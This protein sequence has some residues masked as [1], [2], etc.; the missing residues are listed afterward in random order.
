MNQSLKIQSMKT[1]LISIRSLVAFSFQLAA[2]IEGTYRKSGGALMGVCLIGFTLQVCGESGPSWT[3]RALREQA[4]SLSVV[5]LPAK[6]AEIVSDSPEK[7]RKRLAV[8]IVR[9]FLKERHSL[10]PSLVGSICSAAPDVSVVVTAEAVQLFPESAYSIVK[11][12]VASAPEMAVSIC[13]Q[14]SIEV[15]DR[16]RQ[17]VNAVRRAHPSAVTELIGVVTVLSAARVETV[18]AAI[19]STRNRIGTSLSNVPANLN[20]FRDNNSP[21]L[22]QL[23]F[24]DGMEVAENLS[25]SELIN[26][27]DR[28][29]RELLRGDDNQFDDDV[30]IE[31]YVQ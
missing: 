26:H 5:E 11:A 21:G 8:R 19:Q 3:V 22:L 1:L 20:D 16:S 18:D 14:A 24:L 12:A 23:R 6:A 25:G 4:E 10:A 28:I 7:G 9:V 30:V 31:R 13:L 17:I 15:P 2:N 29:R 27:F